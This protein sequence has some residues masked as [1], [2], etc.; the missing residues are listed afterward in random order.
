MKKKIILIY[1]LLFTLG[2]LQASKGVN[3]NADNSSISD[4]I[5]IDLS[6]TITDDK[7][8]AIEGVAVS[9]GYQVVLTNKKGEYKMMRSPKAEFVYYT[10]PAEYEINTAANG[11]SI[12]SFYQ[13]LNSKQK[14]YNF[15]LR[16]L[17]NGIESRF[18]VLM[19]G[20]PQ[21]RDNQSVKRFTEE[22]IPDVKGTITSSSVPSYVIAL[23]DIV[24]DKAELLAPIR[25]ALGSTEVP[26][27]LTIGNHDKIKTENPEIMR[28]TKEYSGAFGPLNYSFDRGNVH[29][30]CLD[31]VIFTDKDKHT[32]GFTDEQ[33]LWLKQDLANVPNEKM[34]I[35]YYHIPLRESD[36][37]N[38]NEILIQLKR[39]ANVHLMCGHTHYH[40]NAII[41][42]PFNVYE[43]I[44]GATC[45]AWWHSTLNGDGTPIG[46]GVF[47]VNGTDFSNWYYKAVQYDKNHQIRLY[48]GDATFGG[49]YGS[50]TF[51]QRKNDIIAN[52]WN[53]DNTW[54]IEVYEDGVLKGEMQNVSST[55]GENVHVRD[56]WA[57]G[58]HV[59]VK[60]RKIA[61]FNPPVRHMYMYRL[62][63]PDAK[64]KVVATDRFGNKYEEDR[65]TT[66]M[67]TAEN[68]AK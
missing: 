60:N 25:E 10:T 64:I 4:K 59:G 67:S 42:E 7:G 41:N 46:Y 19:L 13:P 40:E 14:K 8:K 24:Y 61:S 28:S 62:S 9:D 2:G 32:G 22:I 17:P 6:G 37:K 21:V 38:K 56:A 29:F 27:F 20:D 58:F 48:R 23:G 52:I 44:H 43:H 26:V 31:N 63:N 18:N 16:R 5:R 39:F 1:I 49:E 11:M 33:V 45:G 65:I 51:G 12:A 57:K 55:L 30:I 35:L 53:A 66:D 54:K 36:Y 68:Y 50:F 47:E 3:N 34:V 15:K